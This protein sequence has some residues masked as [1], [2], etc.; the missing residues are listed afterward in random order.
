[1]SNAG[2]QTVTVSYIDKTTTYQITVEEAEV[3]EPPVPEV[4]TNGTLV[5]DEKPTPASKLESGKYLFGIYD[6]D[7]KTTFNFMD[8]SKR[9][10]QVAET[11]ITNFEE[12]KDNYSSYYFSV[13]INGTSAQIYADG[14]CDGKA[15][16]NYFLNPSGSTSFGLGES[17]SNWSYQQ[18]K[19]YAETDDNGVLFYSGTR[20]IMHSNSGNTFRNYATSNISNKNYSSLYLYRVDTAFN[21]LLKKLSIATCSDMLTKEFVDRV[22]YLYSKLSSEEK[23]LMSTTTYVGADKNTYTMESGYQYV[24]QRYL[25][26]G[27]ESYNLQVK[28]ANNTDILFVITLSIMSVSLIVVFSFKKKKRV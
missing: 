4:N 26:T 19:V 25:S 11:Q 12:N 18:N 28:M 16:T 10:T 3:K 22:Q 5:V 17:A 1:M 24:M 20:G 13:T 7:T 8:P 21:F 15:Y 9:A 6:Y 23:T 2:T 27:N 14:T